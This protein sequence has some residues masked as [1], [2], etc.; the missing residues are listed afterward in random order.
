MPSLS[1]DTRYI[2][3][4]FSRQERPFIPMAAIAYGTQMVGAPRRAKAAPRSWLAGGATPCRAR[5]KTGADASVTMCRAGCRDAICEAI[6][7][8]IPSLIV[9]ITEGIP[10][11]TWCG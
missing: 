8:E 11:S 2:L 6:D 9:C 3:P 5:D 4:R 1:A 7:A 10:C